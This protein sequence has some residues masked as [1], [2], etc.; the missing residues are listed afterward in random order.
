M[1]RRFDPRSGR[2]DYYRKATAGGTPGAHTH[3]P[4]DVIPQGSGSLLDADLLDGKTSL[5]F[6]LDGHTHSG[7]QPSDAD[8]TAIAALNGTGYAKRTGVDSWALEAAAAA[9]HDHVYHEEL[10]AGQAGATWQFSQ[11]HESGSERVRLN[12]LPLRR[13]ASSPGVNEYT[14]DV[15]TYTITLWAS[16]G[17]SDFLEVDYDIAAPRDHTHVYHEE[18]GAGQSGQVWTLD[19]VPD[20]GTES[21]RLN[22]YPLRRVASGADVNEYTIVD[23]E[24]TL[25]ASKSA[26]DFLEADYVTS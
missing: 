1:P 13:V 11:Q 8:L 4:A 2:F 22:N 24:V 7:F 23:D 12:N 21:L 19:S 9:D 15:P 18:L 25:W 26:S 14:I 17:V 16:K 20:A 10:G 3:P 6:S 5:D